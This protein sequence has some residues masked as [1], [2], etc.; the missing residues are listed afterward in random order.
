MKFAANLTMMFNEVPFLNRFQS[1]AKAGFDGVEYLFPYPYDP[2]ELDDH[3]RKYDLAQVLFNHPAG[4]W[5]SGDRGL[6]CLPDRKD[7]FREGVSQAIQYAEKL[8]CPQVNCL[9][10]VVDQGADLAEAR[11]ILV[12][13]LRFAAD[14]LKK[15]GIR[16]L[17]EPV[18]TTD[19]PGSFVHLSSQAI[20]II[21]DVDSDNL[22][23]QYDIYH[24]QVMEGN[25]IN[26][27]KRHFEIIKHI[28][29]ADNPGRHEPGTGEINYQYIF[30]SLDEMG[31][32][33]WV[34]GEYKPLGTTES[35]LGWEKP[36]I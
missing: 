10:G 13:N 9:A 31:Y 27:I 23:L 20:S 36:V 24:M 30:Q 21:E 3:L 15:A 2:E 34:S 29:V 35:G 12:E 14:E 25:L 4:D 26:T 1:A 17:M 33:G 6:A 11:S 5:E 16:L 32:Q 19:I 18:N 28:Q 7:E 8:K 22:F